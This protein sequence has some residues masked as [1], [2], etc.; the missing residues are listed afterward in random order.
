MNNIFKIRNLKYNFRN[1]ISFATRSVNSV[2]YGSENV[3][4][5]GPKGW[6]LLSK[7]INPIQD[8]PFWGCTRM[9]GGGTKKPPLKNLSHIPNIDETWHSYTLPKGDP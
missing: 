5:L 4:Y 1:D 6:D 9:G 8:G 7:N 2:H 3:S